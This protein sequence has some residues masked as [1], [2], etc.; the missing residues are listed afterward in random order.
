[1][2]FVRPDHSI[3]VGSAVVIQAHARR[4]VPR[5][6][7]EKAR[8]ARRP[9]SLVPGPVEAK[10]GGPRDVGDDV[11]FALAR[12][13]RHDPTGLIPPLG[14]RYLDALAGGLPR[15]ASAGAPLGAC[16]RF[17]HGEPP[18][19]VLEHRT[20]RLRMRRRQEG[21]HKHIGIPEHM[22]AV[23]RPAQAPCPDCGFA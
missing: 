14:G 1:V 19:A 6:R 18:E 22:S 20:S 17:G 7:R 16:S 12:A 9:E 11:L 2:V 5:R 8:G 21:E 10:G 23:R 3:D 15:K 13:D 4:P